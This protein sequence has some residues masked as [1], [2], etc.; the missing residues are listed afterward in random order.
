MSHQDDGP[1]FSTAPTL[2]TFLYGLRVRLRL[3]ADVFLALERAE[4]TTGGV[5]LS[6]DAFV[7]LHKILDEM[8]DDADRWSEGLPADALG[9]RLG[10][11]NDPA[12]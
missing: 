11:A 8:A 9:Q 3:F 7:G 4:S 2:E 12:S 1:D 10:T 6:Q 5:N